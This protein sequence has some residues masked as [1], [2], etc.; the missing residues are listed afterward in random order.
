[1]A[2]GQ[3]FTSRGSGVNKIFVLSFDG[4]NEQAIFFPNV[5]IRDYNVMIDG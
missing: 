3:T 1:M 2:F 4:N 5:E